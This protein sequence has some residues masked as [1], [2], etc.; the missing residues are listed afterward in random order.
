[1]AANDMMAI[2]CYDFMR[3]SGLR[4]PSD[5]GVVGFDDIFVA[6]Y[7]TPPLTTIRVHIEE[8]GKSA[9]DILIKRIKKEIMPAKL[10]IKASSELIIRDSC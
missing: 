4:I 5:I 2:G 7:L 9:A 3:E 10:S 6:Q 1:V 8:I